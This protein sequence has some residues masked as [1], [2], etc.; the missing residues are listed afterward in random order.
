VFRQFS[1]N[2]LQHFENLFHETGSPP[3]ETKGIVLAQWSFL[4]KNSEKEQTLF[5][6]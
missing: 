2:S 6:A 4:K 1:T 3:I 5:I